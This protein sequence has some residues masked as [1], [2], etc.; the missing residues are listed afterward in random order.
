MIVVKE[1]AP[2]IIEDSEEIKKIIISICE[3]KNISLSDR[4]SIKVLMPALKS[5]GCDMKVAQSVIKSMSV[6]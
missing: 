2:R 4:S 1:Y 5:A 6:S 3:E